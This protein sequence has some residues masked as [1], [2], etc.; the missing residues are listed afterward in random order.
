MKGLKILHQEIREQVN[1]IVMEHL[2]VFSSTSPDLLTTS[3][4][5]TRSSLFRDKN[6]YFKRSEE[7]SLKVIIAAV[8]TLSTQLYI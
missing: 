3:I 2:T 6:K 4:T 5:I 8:Y 7:M 1:T